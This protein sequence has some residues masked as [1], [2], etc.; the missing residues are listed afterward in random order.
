MGVTHT[1]DLLTSTF[2]AL[3]SPQGT[4]TSSTMKNRLCSGFQG[5]RSHCLRDPIRHGRYSE[6]TGAPAM[7]F[8]YF[9][10]PY[11]RWKIGPRGHPVPD[12]VEIVLQILLEFLDGL[13]VHP[14]S[15]LVPSDAMRERGLRSS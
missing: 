9:N 15:T 12:S 13:S 10:C 14:G 11:R 5:E 3:E 2:A 4:C 1:A 7:R 8:R 6:D